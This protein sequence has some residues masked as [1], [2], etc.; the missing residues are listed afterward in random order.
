MTLFINH[1]KVI[2]SCNREQECRYYKCNGY[3]TYGTTTD[4]FTFLY[5]EIDESIVDQIIRESY[6][7]RER[8]YQQHQ[9]SA[10][11]SHINPAANWSGDPYLSC[12]NDP[13]YVLGT[14][15]GNYIGAQYGWASM[16]GYYSS[17]YYTFDS[18][19]LLDYVQKLKRGKF[20]EENCCIPTECKA[21]SWNVN[22]LSYTY[23]VSYDRYSIPLFCLDSHAPPSTSC[24]GL[25]NYLK[26]SCTNISQ[27]YTIDPRPKCNEDRYEEDYETYKPKGDGWEKLA[28]VITYYSVI[29]EPDDCDCTSC[30]TCIKCEDINVCEGLPPANVVLGY[31]DKDLYEQ[32]RNSASSCWGFDTICPDQECSSESEIELS[33]LCCQ[34]EDFLSYQTCL[35]EK[36][37]ET[38]KVT[39]DYCESDQ[40][41]QRIPSRVREDIMCNYKYDYCAG[42]SLEQTYKN[43]YYVKINEQEDKRC[44]KYACGDPD[45]CYDEYCVPDSA[46]EGSFILS[47]LGGQT[48]TIEFTLTDF[49]C[50][51]IRNTDCETKS[52]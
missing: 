4:S 12:S 47:L 41:C 40:N 24:D 30:A 15:W 33:V 44:P 45:M 27:Q 10:G 18:Y 7:G 31:D 35:I 49:F 3:D 37:K 20:L 9:Y 1:N 43:I 46:T 39:R 23:T 22:L 38:K 16:F 29:T 19:W 21:C 50:E 36:N 14:Q 2:S 32:G 48:E 52:D 8:K 25:T 26:D 28:E 34:A 51:A 11:T 42:H 6:L 5:R 13:I 17:Y